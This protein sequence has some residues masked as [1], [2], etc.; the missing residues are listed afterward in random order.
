[1]AKRVRRLVVQLRNLTRERLAR[2]AKRTG[3]RLAPD[4]K[5]HKRLA[6]EAKRTGEWLARDQEEQL[7]RQRRFRQLVLAAIRAEK[8]PAP[9]DVAAALRELPPDPAAIASIAWTD[10]ERTAIFNAPDDL[11]RAATIAKL[12]AAISDER[13]RAAVERARTRIADDTAALCAYVA[14][15]FVERTKQR[16][17]GRKRGW[18]KGHTENAQ[19]TLREEKQIAVAYF[20][21]R[22]AN[23]RQRNTK[24]EIA[25]R[26][27]IH[28][29]TLERI[30]AGLK[31]QF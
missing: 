4:Q 29:R 27:G 26:Y 17:V 8:D 22:A 11:S 23:P 5:A 24:E 15:T 1:M 21:A 19:R 12:A 10:D 14:G 3:E 20:E 2:E 13:R 25:E 6:R 18:R 16:T 28:R 31:P 7:R 30:I 9:T